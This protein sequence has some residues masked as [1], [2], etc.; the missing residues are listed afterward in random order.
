MTWGGDTDTYR[1]SQHAGEAW[2]ALQ[3]TTSELV[4]EQEAASPK[5]PCLPPRDAPHCQCAVPSLG[6]LWGGWEAP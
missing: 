4:G 5:Q 3:R 1:A 2:Q 6:Y